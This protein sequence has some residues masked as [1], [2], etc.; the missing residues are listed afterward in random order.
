MPEKPYKSYR[1]RIIEASLNYEKEKLISVKLSGNTVELLLSLT[2]RT[3]L[4]IDECVKK[5]LNL[6]KTHL[7][8]ES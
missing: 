4:P 3:G 1:D 7:S 5:A 2:S 8:K 6:L